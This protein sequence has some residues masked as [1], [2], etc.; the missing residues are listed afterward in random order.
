LSAPSRASARGRTALGSPNRAAT[1]TGVLLLSVYV[2]TGAPALTFWDA[3]EFATAI[4][5]FGI[6][7]PPGTP[8]YVAAGTALWRI[9]P[10]ITPVQAGSLLSAICT[11]LACALAAAVI[12][13][14]TRCTR[15]G[16]IAAVCAGAMGTVWMNAT[17]TEVYAASL[18]CAVLQLAL[19]WRAHS[20][21]DDRARMAVAYVA[22]LSIPVH[23]SAL[24]AT[25]AAILLATTRGD[26][27]VQLR[28]LT[29][30]AML[31]LATLSLS[32]GLLVAAGVAL[33]AA[34]W[35]G[36]TGR[37]GHANPTTRGSAWLRQGAVLTLL[38]WSGVFILLLR[39]RHEPFLDQGAPTGLRELLA[40]ITRAQYDVAPLWPRRAPLVL[41][42]GNLVQYADWQ[43]ALGLWNDV[44]PALQR[45]PFTLL[46]AVIGTVGAVAHWRTHRVTARAMQLLMLCATLGV[47]LQLNLRAGPSYGAGVLP[48]TALHEARE[49]DY[50]FA[51]AFW[52]WG[53][54]IGVGAWTL[55]RR[56]RWP[57]LVAAV[58]PACMLAGNWTAIVRDVLPDRRVA[59]TIAD[60]LL[61][62]VPANGM[63][64]TAGDND[65][66]P[67]WY[68]QAIDSVRRDVQVV[69]TPLLPANWYARESAFRT[70][71]LQADTSPSSSALA[72]AGALA[73]QR[74]SRGGSVA[75]SILIAPTDRDELGRIAGVTCW[76]RAG[77]IDIGTRRALCPPR[78]DVQR[79]MA[80]ARRLMPL[81]S[82]RARTS[83][84]G[85]VTAFLEV[86]RCP[87]AVARAAMMPIPPADS[88]TRR[89]LDITCNLR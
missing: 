86:A 27:R 28:A 3:S 38:A 53:L 52:C 19:A 9:V 1:I 45:T 7:H 75:V 10:V 50:F 81:A 2:M 55:A 54:W 43:V 60:E 76:R 13:Q 72:R 77:L 82:M 37:E 69:V 8:L 67:L 40:V 44:M 85:M 4:G 21:D 64:F 80:S 49:R 32:R 22:A 23:L 57:G 48:L 42:L 62:N 29:G 59:R 34:A 20:R 5:T 26:G 30:S 24:V 39:A 25:P 68:R 36:A 73:A 88:A 11:A 16:V 41:Q 12:T 14:I 65:S 58:A 66:Y 70:G 83:P 78:V 89:L 35:C 71:R 84:D 74:V 18:L 47:V 6:P 56:A 31:V 87:D 51:L 17:E 63:L 15:A 46:A 61:A 79:S 33:A